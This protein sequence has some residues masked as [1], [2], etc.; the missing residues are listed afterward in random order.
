MQ[1]QHDF[2]LYDPYIGAQNSGPADNM[3]RYGHDFELLDMKI[4][5]A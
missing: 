2:F 3:S 5:I 1:V 4:L